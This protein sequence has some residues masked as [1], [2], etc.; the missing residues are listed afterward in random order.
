[1][2]QQIADRRDVDFV[3]YE[4]FD[5]TSLT[6]HGSYQG[7]NKKMFDMIITEARNFAIKEVLPI[8]EEGD[9]TGVTF[10]DNQV[11]VPACFHRPYRLLCEGEW[12]KLSVAPDFGGQGF[13][14]IV[15]RAAIEYIVGADFSFG[16]FWSLTHG[17]AK[18]IE[19]FGTDSQKEM[20]LNK[21][22]SGKW[23]GT[24]VL[25]EPEAGSEVGNLSTSAKKNADGTYSITGN[26]IF[27]TNG[28]HDL[29]ENIIHPVLARIEGAPDG[30]RG[31]SLFIVPKIWVNEDGSLGEPNDVVCTG[32]E[33]KLGMHASPTCQLSFGSRSTCRGLLLGE[34]NK[35]MRVM[36]HMMNEARLGVG[37]LGLYN[38]SC[39][40]LYALNYARQRVQGKDMDEIGSQNPAQVP[41]IRHP[42]VRR[43]LMWM[44]THMEGMRSIIYYLDYL[45]DRI[46]STDSAEEKT[47]LQDMADLLTPVIKSYCTDRGFEITVLAM[48]CYGGYGYTRDY[49]VERLLRD[50]KINSIY[51]GTNGIQAMDLLGRKLGMKEGAVFMNLLGE[52]QKTVAEAR[53][54]PSLQ[55]LAADME[56]AVTQL[57]NAAMHMSKI[58]SSKDFKVAFAH[59]MSFL[60]VTGD[61]IMAWMLLW[62]AVVAM[63]KLTKILGEASGEKKMEKIKKNKNAAFYEGQLQS[64]TYFIETVLPG[65]AGKIKS[66]EKSCR[67]AV[68]MPEASF[69][70]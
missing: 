19:V 37:A 1:M 13:P 68:D 34:E 26:K 59:A 33:E 4:Q 22:Y 2:A 8:N 45:F 53:E 56:T 6:K 51:E 18:M 46:E 20:F 41:I 62:R 48:Q 32:I 58:A 17:A 36:F 11:R 7:M 61:T 21:M 10:E 3:L 39:A 29:T 65:T 54:I 25:T 57:G 15:T 28:D 52:M 31:I 69:C 12:P 49:P 55:G 64:A 44:K 27:I 47:A 70:G 40:Y 9:Q 66:L 35:G 42:D 16:A 67:A 23:T 50:S 60:E 38:A 30:T 43:M 14:R 5:A 24:M 63:P